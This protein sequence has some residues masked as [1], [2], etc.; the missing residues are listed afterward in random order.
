MSL[1]S[2]NNVSLSFNDVDVLKNINLRIED[3][4]LNII[5]GKSGSGKSSLLNVLYGI[6]KSSKGGVLFAGKDINKFS[7]SEF[8]F[9]HSYEC[10]IV[11]QHFNLFENFSSID[12]VALPL[13]I[14]GEKK[15]KP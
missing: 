6:L 13:L 9:F 4:G 15:K 14:R 3:V 12:N 10:S 2:L 8:S 11:F 1:Y 5:L 7:D